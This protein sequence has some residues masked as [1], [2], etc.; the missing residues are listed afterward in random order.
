MTQNENVKV[1]ILHHSQDLHAI[2]D[3]PWLKYTLSQKII[4]GH[5]LAIFFLA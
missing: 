2:Q 1:K 3:K 4:Y 5:A